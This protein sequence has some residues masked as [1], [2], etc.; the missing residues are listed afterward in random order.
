[1]LSRAKDRESTSSGIPNTAIDLFMTNAATQRDNQR[2]QEVA[3]GNTLRKC[4]KPGEIV[5]WVE[6]HLESWRQLM[7]FIGRA[8]GKKFDAA[9]EDQ[10]LELKGVIVRELEMILASGECASPVKDDIH[11][12]MNSIPSLRQLSQVNDGALHKIEHQWHVIYIG[13][14]SALGRLKAKY[15]TMES[16]HPKSGLLEKWF[17]R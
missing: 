17:S 14:H 1:M 15:K 6:N 16:L 11:E 7:H 2:G 8:A 4:V 12:M 10:F 9:D 5:L 13:W 3:P